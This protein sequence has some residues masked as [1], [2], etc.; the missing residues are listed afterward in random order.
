MYTNGDMSRTYR[1]TSQLW[2]SL[3]EHLTLSTLSNLA[4]TLEQIRATVNVVSYTHIYIFRSFIPEALK[5]QSVPLHQSSTPQGQKNGSATT[6]SIS[7]ATTRLCQRGHRLL[8][9]PALRM[10]SFLQPDSVSDGLLL[11]S[12]AEVAGPRVCS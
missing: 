3:Q 10:L 2:H 9:S 7:V 1:R 11:L 8:L 4:G 6:F 5:V 12:K